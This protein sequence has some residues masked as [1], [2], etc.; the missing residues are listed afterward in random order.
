M[1]EAKNGHALIKGEKVE[2]L[3]EYSA[4]TGR[5]LQD[6]LSTNS[7]GL[8]IGEMLLPEERAAAS[9]TAYL[10]MALIDHTSLDYVKFYDALFRLLRIKRLLKNES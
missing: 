9:F 5:V 1:I 2:I 7:V 3:H 6:I 4:I 8:E 10:D